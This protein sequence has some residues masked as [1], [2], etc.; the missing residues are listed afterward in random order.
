M[1]PEAKIKKEIVAYLKSLGDRCWYAPYVQNGYGKNGVPDYLVC[2]R[3]RFLALEVK[4]E[5]GKP[6][7]WQT[8]Q[9][10]AIDAALGIAGVVT[11]AADVRKLL[12]K[13]ED[14]IEA[15]AEAVRDVWEAA[16]ACGP[17]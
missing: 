9:I 17:R 10:A 16:E 2:Y 7:P 4:K 13:I 8:Y 14:R 15:E 6:T 5:G 11:S 12:R 3:G 1:T